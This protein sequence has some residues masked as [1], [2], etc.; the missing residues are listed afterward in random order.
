M[1]Q[2]EA[3]EERHGDGNTK[4]EERAWK[5]HGDLWKRQD[6]LAIGAGGFDRRIP[7]RGESH[8]SWQGENDVRRHQR[9]ADPEADK[10]ADVQQWEHL[11]VLRAG[12]AKNE[13]HIATI[14]L[15]LGTDP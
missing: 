2:Y 7:D 1:E 10:D 4:D 6:C 8:R 14:I 9:E 11:T 12:S 13:L 3:G 5:G 15:T